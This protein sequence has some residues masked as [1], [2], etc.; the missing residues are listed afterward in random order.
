VRSLGL[1]PLFALAF[2]PCLARGAPAPI[3]PACDYRSVTIAALFAAAN[4]SARAVAALDS[5]EGAGAARALD[6]AAAGLRAER[7][8]I[9]R[10]G[11]GQLAAAE[12]RALAKALRAARRG[13]AKGAR[14]SAKGRPSAEGD[15]AAASAAVASALADQVA[16]HASRS[17]VAP[18]LRVPELFVASGE[19]RTVPAG[20]AITG[21]LGVAILGDLV[22]GGG[23]TIEAESGDVVLEG[24]IDARGGTP[25]RSGAR[26]PRGGAAALADCGDAA[27]VVVRARRGDVRIGPRFVGAAGDGGDCPPLVVTDRGQLDETVPQPTVLRLAGRDGG[28]GGSVRVSAPA[29]SIVFATRPLGDPGVFWPGDGGAGES[30]AVE[31]ELA[32]P[33]GFASVR[34]SGGSGGSSGSVALDARSA[35]VLPLYRVLA[36]GEGGRGG[37]VEWD[38]R[39]GDG[40]F[41]SGLAEVYALG[42]SGGDGAAVG[43]RGGDARYE[44]D[45]IV[46]AAGEPTTGVVAVGGLGGGVFEDVPRM[47]G[48]ETRGGDGGGA[49]ATG[50]RGADGTEA[51]PDGGAGGAVEVAGGA[52][53]V[54]F[55]DPARSTG[56]D[57]GDASGWGGRGGRGLPSCAAPPG[58][59]GRG[60]AGGRALVLAGDGGTA[61]VHGG[62]GGDSLTAVSGRPG[63]GGDGAPAGDCGAVSEPASVSGAGGDGEARGADGARAAPETTPCASDSYTCDEVG[64]PRDPCLSPRS[65]GA[66]VSDYTSLAD[67]RIYI[68]RET[69]LSGREI[70]DGVTVCT[71]HHSG[72]VTVRSKYYDQ[73]ETSSTTPIEQDWGSLV[74]GTHRDLLW[75]DHCTADGELHR[76]GGSGTDVSGGSPTLYRI[77]HSCTG[78]CA[79]GSTAIRCCPSGDGWVPSDDPLCR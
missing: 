10:T 47:P 43:G 70:C 22:A 39:L 38:V 31:P 15:A 59:G 53:R 72:S 73:P 41:P 60:G 67:G 63:E 5:G 54:V 21:E 79:C 24:S 37:G 4:D 66:F 23:L 8:R 20:A 7:A 1:V 34:I 30:L 74:F 13:A 69:S 50:H 56:G 77:T 25:R 45:R 12:R 36:G 35:E 19:T 11:G 57:G 65:Y 33:A 55:D 44:G 42:G 62:A 52:G 46:N 18:E 26:A 17:C 16:A 75:Y 28:D 58:A 3:G 68:L 78:A 29:G 2:A 61:R 40:A 27:D 32:P 14:S 9:A 64:A 49:A 76:A 51:H 71:A 48:D 6:A